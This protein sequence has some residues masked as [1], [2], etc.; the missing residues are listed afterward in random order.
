MKILAIFC[1]GGR[2]QSGGGGIE[3]KMSTNTNKVMWR[4]VRVLPYIC[5]GRRLVQDW[6]SVFANSIK[7]HSP[8]RGCRITSQESR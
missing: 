8:Q 4:N 5:T 2:G 7:G 1:V 6:Y 3:P